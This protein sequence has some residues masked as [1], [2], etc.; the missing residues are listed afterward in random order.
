MRISDWPAEER[1]REKLLKL[2]AASLSNAELLAVLIGHG[3]PGMTAVDLARSAL[4]SFGGLRKLLDATPASIGSH[5]GWGPARVA[6][7]LA[8]VELSRRHLG[9]EIHRSDKLRSPS[10]TRNFLRSRLR[11][12]DHEVFA[13]LFLDNQ[14]RVLAY[15]ELFRGTLDSCTV[16][17]REVVKRSLALRAGA[18]ILAHNHPSGAAEPS[19]ADRQITRRLQEALALVEVRTLDHLVIGDG[20]PV[21]FAERGWL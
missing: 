15:E 17:P 4:V 7:L 5:P 20:E 18:V 3:Q 8:T 19:N 12:Y 16:H 14:H 6:R 9:E 1:P 11:N 13:V 10:D 21:S 2:G